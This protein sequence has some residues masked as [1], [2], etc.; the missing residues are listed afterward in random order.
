LLRTSCK[1]SMKVSIGIFLV[2]LIGLQFFRP[3]KNI[4]T[5]APGPD[6]LSVMY[7][8]PVAV[9]AVLERAC[10][11]CHSNNTHYPWYAEVQPVGWWL[12]DHVQEAKSH[13][14]FSTFGTYAAKKQL[15][16]LEELM[17]EVQDGEMPLS[18][19]KLAHSDARLTTEEVKSLVDWARIV[20]SQ[21]E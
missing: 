6:D 12:A 13:F 19:Y 1:L 2:L 17:D 8:P 11:D 15:H 10:Y 4:S 21:L 18:S 7:P 16:K 3:V 9:K 5:A 14:N 20:H